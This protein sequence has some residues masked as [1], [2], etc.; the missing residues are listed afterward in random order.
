MQ[1]R[2]ASTSNRTPQRRPELSQHFFRD[3]AFV[4]QWVG[5]LP[6]CHAEPVV[7]VGPG[8]GAITDALADRGLRVVAVELDERL[9]RGLRA[10][11]AGRANV[12]IVQGDFLRHRLPRERYAVVGNVPFAIS[13]DVLRRLIE[14]PTPPSNAWLVVQAEAAAKFAGV[15]RE[16]LFS[17]LHKPVF[18]FRITRTFRRADFEPPPRVRTSLLHIAHRPAPLLERRE[19]A[20]YRA[21]V[22]GTFGSGRTIAEALRWRLTRRQI[23]RLSRDIGFG[24]SVPPS[25]VPFDQWLRIFRFVEHECLGHDPCRDAWRTA[26]LRFAGLARGAVLDGDSRR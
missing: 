23:V 1:R 3:P 10:R 15:P 18:D 11:F 5:R 7:E 13:S 4:R 6:L 26:V 25:A 19:H 9:V 21:F 8:R 22:R 20:S 12:Q 14:A 24:L 17:L 2:H 16:T